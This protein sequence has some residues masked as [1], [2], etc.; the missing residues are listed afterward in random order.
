MTVATAAVVAA[1]L[2]IAGCSREA[3][4]MPEQQPQDPG[5]GALTVKLNALSADECFRSPE[6][7]PAPNCEK[8]VTQVASV[9]ETARRFVDAAGSQLNRAANEL[10]SGIAA[11]RDNGCAQGGGQSCSTALTDIATAL[12]AVRREVSALPD[13]TTRPS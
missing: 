6:S 7:V 10:A 1:L 9:P 3:G 5:P 11:Y 4:P 13:V 8:Y 12:E 2:T